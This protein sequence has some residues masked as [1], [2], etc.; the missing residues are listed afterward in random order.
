MSRQTILILVLIVLVVG[1]SG[2]WY[3]SH[4][5]KVTDVPTEVVATT[6]TTH[7]EEVKV[8]NN[9]KSAVTSN[10]LE[11]DPAKVQP[12][13]KFGAFT[14]ITSSAYTIGDE[15][16]YSVSFKGP[17]NIQ[18]V[19]NNFEPSMCG[20]VLEISTSTSETLPRVS[21]EKVGSM[22]VY[23]DLDGL[24]EAERVT[25]TSA[26]FTTPSGQLL[27]EGDVLE[28]TVDTFLASHQGKDCSGKRIQVTSLKKLSI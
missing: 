16:S 17:V 26:G 11:F 20:A 9:R 8:E 5:S 2:Y 27:Q 15:H 3:F 10:G 22:N 7:V 28:V 1:V 12:G 14:V 23:L 19:L 21:G 13:E 25:Y 4:Q 6:N 18:G 24:P